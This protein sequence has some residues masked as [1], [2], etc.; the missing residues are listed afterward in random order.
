MFLK[1]IE[2]KLFTGVVVR[3]TH[4]LIGCGAKPNAE[5]YCSI[6]VNF[7]SEW[8]VFVRY[9]KILDVKHYLVIGSFI[10]MQI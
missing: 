4:D 3:S 9:G 8:R 5:C 6:I 2:S 10:M 7:V 1:P